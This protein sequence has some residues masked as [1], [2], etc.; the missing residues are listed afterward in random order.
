MARL[1][2]LFS[3]SGGNSYYIGTSESGVL[4]DAGK[5]AKQIDLALNNNG[6]V[7]DAIKAIFITHEHTDHIQGVRVFASKH[8]IPVFATEGTLEALD[9]KNILNEKFQ[10]EAVKDGVEVDGMKICPFPTSHDCREGCGYMVETSD[11]RKTAFVTDLGYISPAVEKSVANCDTVIL[12]SNHDVGM[13]QSGSYPYELKHRILSKQGHLSNSA[14][15][16]FAVSLVRSGT[17]RLL[18]AHLSQE[19]NMPELA[20]QTTLCALTQENMKKDVDFMLKV[21]PVQNTNGAILY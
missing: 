13:L 21:V 17:T 14:C 10:Y 18:L 8:H 9:E 20:Y 12:E 3:G 7:L 6:I 2:P 11:G 5:S 16:D 4:I 19:N 1:C 15:A